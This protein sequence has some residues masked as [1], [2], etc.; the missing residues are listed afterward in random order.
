MCLALR[1]LVLGLVFFFWLKL[2]FPTPIGNGRLKPCKTIALDWS[3]KRILVPKKR[4]TNLET[5]LLKVRHMS[6]PKFSYLFLVPNFVMKQVFSNICGL[7]MYHHLPKILEWQCDWK[8]FQSKRFIYM[9]CKR[10]VVMCVHT[11]MHRLLRFWPLK[12][13]TKYCN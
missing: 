7:H 1:I 9:R 4:G 3:W 8:R 6:R 13:Y 10:R 12:N 2:S 11:T 5:K